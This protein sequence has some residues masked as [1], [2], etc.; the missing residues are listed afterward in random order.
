MTISVR[1]SYTLSL[2]LPLSLSLSRACVRISPFSP[3][4]HTWA[5]SIDA[6]LFTII[7]IVMGAIKSL[8]EALSPHLNVPPIALSRSSSLNLFFY[9][10]SCSIAA[11]LRRIVDRKENWKRKKQKTK[12]SGWTK[13]LARLLFS[14]AMTAMMSDDDGRQSSNSRRHM[15]IQYRRMQAHVDATHWCECVRVCLYSKFKQENENERVRPEPCMRIIPQNTKK[16]SNIEKHLSLPKSMLIE[17]LVWLDYKSDSISIRTQIFHSES[18]SFRSPFYS[19]IELASFALHRNKRA[20]WFHFIIKILFISVCSDA[21]IPSIGLG[22]PLRFFEV[23]FFHFLSF[24]YVAIIC[25]CAYC[26]SASTECEATVAATA[27]RTASRQIK[28]LNM[29]ETNETGRSDIK[30]WPWLKPYINLNFNVY[31]PLAVVSNGVSRISD[32]ARRFDSS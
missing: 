18:I 17:S 26:C 13:L 20:R 23:F 14:V 28:N 25:C 19:A 32:N 29:K 22:M 30:N 3:S 16:N 11:S 24:N 8:D 31:V 27:A 10:L 6:Q 1:V 21:L 7:E 4:V 9:L 5:R 2:P 12:R 15:S